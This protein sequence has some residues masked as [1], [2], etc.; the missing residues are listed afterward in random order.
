MA[1]L[2]Y[3]NIGMEEFVFDR[4]KVEDLGIGGYRIIQTK[5]G[6][7]FGSDAVLLS[8]F[9]AFKKG[10]RVLDMCTGTGIIPVLCYAQ[11]PTLTIDAVEIMDNVA[12]MAQRTM[13]LNKIS[14]KVRVL[15]GDLKDCIQIYGKRVFDAVT[16]NPPYMNEGGGLVNPNDYLAVARHEIH[17]S[18]DDVVRVA[19]MVLKPHGKLFMVHRADRLCDVIYTFRKYRIEPK[20]LAMV[21]PNSKGSPNL[22]LIEGALYGKVQLKVLPPVFMYDDEGN[23]IQQITD[24]LF[25]KAPHQG[26]A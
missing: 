23:Y 22:I 11:N 24:E 17:C 16:C 8:K 20:R 4:E 10:S 1:F 26:K 5:D 2:V 18:L 3:G 13:E 7:C 21:H 25:D 14:D 9:A 15:S 6:F 19:S 12:S